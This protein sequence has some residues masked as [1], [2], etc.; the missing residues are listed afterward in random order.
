VPRLRLGVALLLTGD[1]AREV[2]GL[3]RACGDGALGRV[4][5]HLTLVPPV[6]VRRDELPT[7]LAVLRTA[8]ACVRP[9]ALRLGPPRTFLPAT[10]TLH[11]AVGGSG[12]STQVLRQLRD[13]VFHP[14]LERPLT[15]PF[16]PHVT[17]ADD[18]EPDRIAAAMDA[19][20]DFVVEAAFDRVHL[21]EET[22]GDDGRRRWRPIADAPFAPAIVVGRGGVELDLA[23][24]HLLDPEAARLV[25]RVGPEGDVAFDVEVAPGAVAIVVAARRRG[26][27]VGVAR[28]WADGVD[29]AVN[30]VVVDP[31]HRR[32]GIARHL[33]V[34]FRHAA[35]G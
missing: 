28:G 26:E 11:L 30:A 20:G 34:A 35:A 33:V 32:Q 19:L 2:D 31:D 29:S 13:A 15:F 12:S 21:L 9:F 3:R 17:L 6:N 7:A 24:S 14:P 10:P 22:R 23:V 25:E 8:A 1:L 18:M 16:V 4:P 27:V 5:P